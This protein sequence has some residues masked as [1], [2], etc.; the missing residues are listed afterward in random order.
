MGSELISLLQRGTT[1]AYLVKRSQVFCNIDK[2][3]RIRLAQPSTADIETLQSRLITEQL[4]EI[5]V[6]GRGDLILFLIRRQ[7]DVMNGA[8]LTKLS[9]Q[10]EQT[11]HAQDMHINARPLARKCTQLH[12]DDRS[13]EYTVCS[14]V[15]GCRGDVTE[16]SSQQ[17][18]PTL[19]EMP[20]NIPVVGL[21]AAAREL[22]ALGDT[23]L[24]ETGDMECNEQKIPALDLKDVG[25]WPSKIK[26]DTRIL[27]VRQRASVA[28]I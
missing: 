17:T 28:N 3:R 15:C 13:K 25:F 24:R 16:E 7:K 14:F 9:E 6:S 20:S 4:G 10:C 5:D 11:Y 21:S 1:D 18:T 27:L 12:S 22:H 23:F 8:E 2:L 19:W 26:E